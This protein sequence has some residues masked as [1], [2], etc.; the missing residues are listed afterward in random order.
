MVSVLPIAAG[1]SWHLTYQYYLFWNRHLACSNCGTGILPA[2]IVEQAS[3]LLKLAL[4][5]FF[6]YRR[7]RQTSFT[8]SVF[9]LTQENVQKWLSCDSKT[10]Q[11]T[12]N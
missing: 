2:Q 10:V 6:C 8:L 5:W 9:R 3:C 4:K 1:A 12:L 11:P 7:D